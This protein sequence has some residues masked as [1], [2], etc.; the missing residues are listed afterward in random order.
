MDSENAPRMDYITRARQIGLEAVFKE[1][2][3]SEVREYVVEA[4][5]TT[6]IV[7]HIFDNYEDALAMQVKLAKNGT[8]S[9]MYTLNVTLAKIKTR[10][11][12]G[13]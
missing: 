1:F 4:F 11:C 10:W 9:Q 5:E 6:G 7:N 13:K 8:P 12:S 3:L 2:G